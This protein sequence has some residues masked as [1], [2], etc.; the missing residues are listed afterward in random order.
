MSVFICISNTDISILNTDINIF[1][2]LSSSI[3]VCELNHLMQVSVLGILVSK[4]RKKIGI[5]VF[6][7][8]IYLTKPTQ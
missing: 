1:C 7:K 8:W 2:K 4:F 3:F 5:S 6:L